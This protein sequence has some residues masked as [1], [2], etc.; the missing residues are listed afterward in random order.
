MYGGGETEVH[1]GHLNAGQDFA[2]ATK[3]NPFYQTPQPV[4]VGLRP[5]QVTIRV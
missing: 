3:V 2:I 5:E 4:A 1:L